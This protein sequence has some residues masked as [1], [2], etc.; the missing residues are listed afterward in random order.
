MKKSWKVYAA[1]ACY[2]LGMLGW[3]YFGVWMILTKPVKELVLA[4]MA[5]DLSIGKAAVAGVQGFIYLTIG[6][7]VWCIGYVLHNSL[8][9]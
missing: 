1:I 8:K 3:I 9:K 7:L 6:G 2:V 5:G 4:Y